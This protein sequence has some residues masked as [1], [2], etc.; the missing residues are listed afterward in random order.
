M[1]I[2]RYHLTPLDYEKIDYVMPSIVRLIYDVAGGEHYSAL[3]RRIK[4]EVGIK[5]IIDADN[6]VGDEKMVMETV[7]GKQQKD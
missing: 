7:H 3:V 5:L 4:L 1:A 6:I 2:S